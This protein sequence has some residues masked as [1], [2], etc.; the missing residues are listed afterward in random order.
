MQGLAR[1]GPQ[2]AQRGRVAT[3]GHVETGRDDALRAAAAEP[4]FEII[5]TLRVTDGRALRGDRHL[6]RMAG[7]AA[8]L[9]LGF[10]RAAAEALLAR[11]PAGDWRVR[12]GL[13]RDGLRLDHA[14]A[15]PP[16]DPM[17]LAL[18]PVRLDAD[19][20]WLRLKTSRRAV[21]D[22]A[23]ASLP[24]GVDEVIFLNRRDELCEGAITTLFVQAG[25]VL[26]T[27]PLACGLLPGV[28]RAELLERGAAREAVLRLPDLAAADAVYVGN[29]LRGLCRAIPPGPT[30]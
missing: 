7:T 1:P 28:L 6:A 25:G 15:P 17:R 5:E 23:R 16:V 30:P 2:V 13:T 24:A 12:L 29:S 11:L 22:A 3:G 9:G 8:R 10:D 27:P 20:P 19:D 18:S 4:G 26:L 21:Y 14:P